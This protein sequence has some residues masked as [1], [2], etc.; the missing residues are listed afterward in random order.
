MGEIDAVDPDLSLVGIDQRQDQPRQGWTCR[1]RFRRRGRGSRRARSVKLTSATACTPARLRAPRPAKRFIRPCDLER[2]AQTRASSA[3][4]EHAG[5]PHGRRRSSA[6][7]GPAAG[8]CPARMGSAAQSDSLAADSV[9]SGALPLDRLERRA[10]VVFDSRDAGQQR[11]RVGMAR[12]VEQRVD[13]GSLDDAPGI[14]DQ[15]LIGHG[16]DNAEIMGD[17]QERSAHL[18]AADRAEA[19]GSWPARSRRAPSSARRR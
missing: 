14:H 18:A 6:A 9:R 12:M 17:Q 8:R 4:H 19:A 3:S 16:G 2:A 15:D 11:L 13:I 1:S 5:Q 7:S 10:T